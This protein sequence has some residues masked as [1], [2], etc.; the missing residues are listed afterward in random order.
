MKQQN[1]KSKFLRYS[2]LFT[3]K[4]LS[5]KLPCSNKKIRDRDRRTD[6]KK[7]AN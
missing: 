5:N 7:N 4:R 6:T 2:N 1:R 3:L